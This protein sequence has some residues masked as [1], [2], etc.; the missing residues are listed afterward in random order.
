LPGRVLPGLLAAGLLSGALLLAGCDGNPGPPGADAP[1]YDHQPPTVRL[2]RPNHTT[3]LIGDTL[4]LYAE[5]YDSAGEIS[6]VEFLV[7]GSSEIG[8]LRAIVTSPPYLFLWNFTQSQTDYGLISFQAMATDTSGN[9]QASP[10]FVLDRKRFTGVD[11]L[12]YHIEGVPQTLWA[13][14]DSV[15]TTDEHGVM[16]DQ[17]WMDRIGTRFTARATG[18]LR[19]VAFYFRPLAGFQPP[20]RLVVILYRVEQFPRPGLPLDSLQIPFGTGSLNRWVQVNMSVLN[21][22]QPYRFQAGESF[23]IAVKMVEPDVSETVRAFLVTSTQSANS[24]S[25]LHERGVIHTE[26]NGW[27]TIG[28]QFPGTGE[29]R[30]YMRAVMRYDD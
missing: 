23:V 30:P 7:N 27:V 10:F 11:T 3:E 21:N 19:N 26:S 13:L 20:V 2:V 28:E 4:T 5:A 9:R 6:E 29:Y 17:T 1:S 22:G 14:A 24:Q 12:R 18:E 25:P 15:L 16:V 8:S